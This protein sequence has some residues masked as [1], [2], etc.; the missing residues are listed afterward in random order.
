MRLLLECHNTPEVLRLLQDAEC[1]PLIEQ[2]MVSLEDPDPRQKRRKTMV[3]E[4]LDS[5]TENEKKK[6]GDA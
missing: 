2:Q 5:E 3:R 6:E 4:A 1:M